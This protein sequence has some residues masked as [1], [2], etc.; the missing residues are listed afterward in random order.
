M[1]F[2]H[3]NV[4]LTAFFFNAVV[5]ADTCSVDAFVTDTD[6]AGLNIRDAPKGKIIA[7]IP[8]QD[9]SAVLLKI[10]DSNKGWFKVKDISIIDSELDYGH[11]PVGWVYG[12]MI[13]TEIKLGNYETGI[14]FYESPHKTSA[15]GIE[16]YHVEGKKSLP[17][18]K[19]MMGCQ[20]EWLHVETFKTKNN[21]AAI[22]WLAPKNQCSNPVTTCP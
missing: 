18:I 13:A 22:G 9:G 20:G 3:V 12:S 15:K 6:P 2:I 17:K 16:L 4:F 1:H 19:R 5:L 14:A 8:T 10:M 7:K 21:S 11:L